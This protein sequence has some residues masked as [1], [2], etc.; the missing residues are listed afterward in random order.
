MVKIRDGFVTNS[1][2]S[3]F[4]LQKKNLNNYQLYEVFNYINSCDDCW[5]V[6]IGIDN[7]RGF[8]TMQDDDIEDLF[9]K[10]DIDPNDYTVGD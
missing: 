6:T 4:I 2:S 10:L 9:K 3:S 5:D 8:T 7:I 1:S